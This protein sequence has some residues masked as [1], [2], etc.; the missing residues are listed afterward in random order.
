MEI[1][2]DVLKMIVA[3]PL[4]FMLFVVYHAFIKRN[5]PQAIVLPNFFDFANMLT[6]KG[7]I[8]SSAVWIIVGSV[9]LFNFIFVSKPK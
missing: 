3:F 4:W 1:I 8:M 2:I 9:I 7:F 6:F 5:Y